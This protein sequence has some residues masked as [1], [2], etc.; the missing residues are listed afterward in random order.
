MTLNFVNKYLFNVVFIRYKII[1]LAED[2]TEAYNFILEDRAAKRL[3]RKTVTKMLA[4]NKMVNLQ[5][6]TFCIFVY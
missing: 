4:E 1:V 5:M 3:T 6:N 2:S